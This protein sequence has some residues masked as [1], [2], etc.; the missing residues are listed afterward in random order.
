MNAR[1]VLNPI[2]CCSA[3]LILGV[4]VLH[5][6]AASAQDF[7]VG[8]VTCT[9]SRILDLSGNY[10]LTGTAHLI[11]L[12]ITQ[13]GRGKLNCSAVVTRTDTNQTTGPFN[14]TGALTGLGKKALR[15]ALI[16]LS[17]ESIKRKDIKHLTD[18]QYLLL[19]ISGSYDQATGV[20]TVTVRTNGWGGQESFSSS[21]IPQNPMRGFVMQDAEASLT[22]GD[23]ARSTRTIVLPWGTRT[24]SAYQI[25]SSD[26]VLFVAN[27]SGFSLALNGTVSGDTVALKRAFVRFSFAAFDVTGSTIVSRST[28]TH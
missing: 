5:T 11:A 19:R 25:I 16:G 14:V 23:F 12:N 6:P 9:D 21:I 28:L 2:W 4:A 26:R 3:I 17:P 22:I 1:A 7:F 20:F 18:D 8:Q 27:E 10:S 24:V 15:V 13:D